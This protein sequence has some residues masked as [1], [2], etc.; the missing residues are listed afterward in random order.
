[1]FCLIIKHLKF[2]SF[3][4][5]NSRVYKCTE[6]EDQP[7]TELKSKTR[8]KIN[9]SKCSKTIILKSDLQYKIKNLNQWFRNSH[10]FY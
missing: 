4:K 5:N 9:F 6:Y 10:I 2:Q 8:E 1:M 7:T 3:G